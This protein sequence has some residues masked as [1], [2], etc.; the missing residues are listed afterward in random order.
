MMMVCANSICGDV[1]GLGG[2]G[3][4]TAL[5]LRKAETTAAKAKMNL[6]ERI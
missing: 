6:A 5:V 3:I 1:A 4:A 2:V